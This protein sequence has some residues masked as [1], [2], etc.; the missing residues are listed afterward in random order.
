[1]KIDTPWKRYIPSSYRVEHEKDLNEENEKTSDS[2]I[3]ITLNYHLWLTPDDVI[4]SMYIY[5]IYDF[6]LFN[7]VT[8]TF[9]R[10]TFQFY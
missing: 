1:M 7:Q 6:R 9:W 8:S 2:I 3:Y 10:Y 5:A 4:I